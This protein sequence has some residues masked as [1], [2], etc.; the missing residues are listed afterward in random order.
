METVNS[1]LVKYPGLCCLAGLE[2][3]RELLHTAELFK[4]ADHL[5][6]GKYSTNADVIVFIA[7]P[8]LTPSQ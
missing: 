3:V 5:A 6:G 1:T 2:R 7:N 8:S 4:L